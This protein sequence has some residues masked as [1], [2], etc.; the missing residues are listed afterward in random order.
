MIGYFLGVRR[1][2]RYKAH[3]LEVEQICSL[4]NGFN[5]SP[6]YKDREEAFLSFRLSIRPTPRKCITIGNWCNL[7]VTGLINEK[8]SLSIGDY[9][10]MNGVHIRVDHQ[11]RIGSH[12]MFGPGVKIWDTNNHPLSVAER[13]AQCESIAHEGFIDSYAAGGGDIIIED[14]VWIGMDVLIL[15]PVRIGRGSVVAARS[16]VTKDVPAMTLVAGVPAKKIGDAAE[17]SLTT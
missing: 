1:R 8:G 9:V 12:C 16:V 15:G 5:C 2:K 4:G 6:L 11:L 7:S 10:Y 17:Q 3:R 13:H 14:D